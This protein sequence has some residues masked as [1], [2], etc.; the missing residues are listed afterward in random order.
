MEGVLKNTNTGFALHFVKTYPLL[1][2]AILE[3][4][5]IFP[6]QKAEQRFR[7]GDVLVLKECNHGHSYTGRDV[8][9]TV[10]GFY[11]SGDLMAVE[12]LALTP[13]EGSEQGHSAQ[14]S[15]T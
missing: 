4:S 2:Q 6:T 10:T 15:T 5:K 1:F 12:K 9:V 11:D 8:H 14:G 13:P 7:V 3:G